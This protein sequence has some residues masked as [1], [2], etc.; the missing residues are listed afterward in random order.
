MKY[1]ILIKLH[2][3]SYTKFVSSIF[4]IFKYL[5]D[6]KVKS[7]ITDLDLG[8]HTY[9]MDLNDSVVFY[10]HA[11]VACVFTTLQFH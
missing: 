1:E 11:G 5:S 8:K 7:I 4:K 6:L 9:I 3:I 2:K 10:K